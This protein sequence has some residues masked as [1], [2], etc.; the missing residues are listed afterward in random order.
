VDRLEK[1]PDSANLIALAP[2][3]EQYEATAVA[4]ALLGLWQGA[5]DSGL[6]ARDSGPGVPV[7][8]WVSVGKRDGATPSDLVAVL[9]RECEV[10]KEAIGKIEVRESFSL[11]DIDAGVGPEQVAE[12]LTGK[13]IRKR[14]LVARPDRP[15]P[16]GVQRVAQR[17]PRPKDRRG[18]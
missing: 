7:R 10:S 16:S 3:F 4:A 2:L 12:R 17:L 1:G 13:T 11:V 5:R 9:V 6:G 8:L 14:R 15:S 18:T